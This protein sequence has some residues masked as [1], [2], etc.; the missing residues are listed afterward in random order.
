MLTL[1]CSKCL[2]LSTYSFERKTFFKIA[3][4]TQSTVTPV[5]NEIIIK[6][7][8]NGFT[9]ILNGIDMS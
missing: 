3:D 9:I 1:A 4:A 5:N 6:A 7:V 2:N 8:G